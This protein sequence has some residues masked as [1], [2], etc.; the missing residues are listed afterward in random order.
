MFKL[1]CTLILALAAVSGAAHAQTTWYVD[2]D[3]C[4]CAGT[5]TIGDPFC[6]IQ[7]AID[8]AAASGDE[9]IVDGGGLVLVGIG[10][11]RSIAGLKMP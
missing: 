5:G 7:D 8:A 9:I 2:D 1:C 3:N 6:L 4:P 10:S 11:S